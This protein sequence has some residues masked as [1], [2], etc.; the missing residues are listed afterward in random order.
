VTDER[1]PVGQSFG[2]TDPFL[3]MSGRARSR[4]LSG[5]IEFLSPTERHAY[6]EALRMHRDQM[7]FDVH[8]RVPGEARARLLRVLAW[9]AAASKSEV[10]TPRPH[11]TT[12]LK[13]VRQR[14]LSTFELG[15]LS[16]NLQ[17]TASTA[18]APELL[19]QV[20]WSIEA[21]ALRR[22]DTRHALHIA[23]KK[24]R[25]GQWTRPHRMPP[26]WARALS[27]ASAPEACGHA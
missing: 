11:E 20:V 13:T 16:R 1:H 17:S 23:L 12:P 25:E 7:P 3:G 21:G 5:L 27:N 10:S 6:G 26:N 24:I 14:K 19:R 9:M 18:T 4:A 2:I 22:F 8:S 15:H